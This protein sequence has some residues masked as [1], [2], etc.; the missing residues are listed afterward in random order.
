[1]TEIEALIEN[2]NIDWLKEKEEDLKYQIELTKNDLRNILENNID[3]KVRKTRGHRLMV[4]YWL[5]KREVI[6]AI[7]AI[8]WIKPD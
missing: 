6:K 3:A 1:M 5:I 7:N 2:K 8:E 4:E